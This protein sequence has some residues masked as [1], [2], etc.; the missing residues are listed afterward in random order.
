MADTNIAQMSVTPHTHL[1]NGAPIYWGVHGTLPA[2]EN[3]VAVLHQNYCGEERVWGY[4]SRVCLSDRPHLCQEATQFQHPEAFPKFL[5]FK[6][7]FSGS[8]GSWQKPSCSTLGRVFNMV[9]ATGKR[10]AFVG[11]GERWTWAD[12]GGKSKV[13]GK[14]GSREPER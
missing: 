8:L 2:E 12:V 10:T 1:L 7:H 5:F 14:R 11:G 3:P 13:P 4:V 6:N 9:P